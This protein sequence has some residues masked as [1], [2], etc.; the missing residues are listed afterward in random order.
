VGER[1]ELFDAAAT[2]LREY[3]PELVHSKMT[4]IVV[5]SA[6]A[7]KFQDLSARA[8]QR[9]AK[10]ERER[11][12]EALRPEYPDAIRRI[13]ARPDAGGD[14]ARQPTVQQWGVFDTWQRRWCPR[15]G[16]EQEMGDHAVKLNADGVCRYR[17]LPLPAPTDEKES[18]DA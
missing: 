6:L 14:S 7:N 16:T 17:P 11:C 8:E 13:R 1:D 18:G 10:R 12:I 4:A 5:A 15:F 2:W 9:G 3:A